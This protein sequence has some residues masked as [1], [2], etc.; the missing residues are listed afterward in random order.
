MKLEYIKTGTGNRVGNTIYL[1]EKLKSYPRL[2]NAILLHE[3]RHTGGFSWFDFKLD[4]RNKEMNSLRWDYYKF[5]L[6]NPE[7]LWNFLPFMK[8]K[9]SWTYDLSIL[10]IWII[11]ISIGVIIWILIG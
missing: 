2:H 7:T 9:N 4:W 1:N 11:T 10:F 3:K 8:I 6:N 5:I